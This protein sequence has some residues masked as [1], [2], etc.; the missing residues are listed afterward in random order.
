AIT[1]CDSISPVS[2]RLGPDFNRARIF[3]NVLHV[4]AD[5]IPGYDSTCAIWARKDCDSMNAIADE[6]SNATEFSKLTP[7]QKLAALLL[8]L[9]TDNAARLMGELDDAEMENV[10]GEMAKFASISQEL[11]R[12]VLFEFSGVA[13][14]AAT[15]I[16][17]GVERVKPILEKAVGLF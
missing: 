3:L 17:G 5:I 7:P 8:I 6:D 12:D 1:A 9:D 15:A 10:S 13:V 14:E 4:C 16:P 11:Q 2:A